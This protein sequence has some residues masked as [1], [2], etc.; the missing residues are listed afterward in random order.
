MSKPLWGGDTS[1]PPSNTANSEYQQMTTQ[2]ADA[3][4]IDKTSSVL[5]TIPD[6]E[7]GV[8]YEKVQ[9]ARLLTSSEYTLN[10]AL[11]YVS[12]KSTLQTDQVLAV[13]YEY[14]L[15][16]RTYQVGEFSPSSL[17]TT[18]LFSKSMIF[19]SVGRFMC[20]IY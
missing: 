6:F 10:S 8:D 1:L 16:G 5:A 14:T 4:N 3:R 7:G 17:A 19:F 9:S 11:G 2:Y 20:A 18:S 13:A 15:G 12:L